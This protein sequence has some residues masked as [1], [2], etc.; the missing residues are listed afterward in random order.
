SLIRPSFS[1]LERMNPL[2]ILMLLLLF[3]TTTQAFFVSHFNGAPRNEFKLGISPSGRSYREEPRLMPTFELEEVKP[4]RIRPC[5][6]SPIQCL[7][8]RRK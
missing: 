1:P 2:S 7:M 6:Y 4:K 5:F 3:C 8:R